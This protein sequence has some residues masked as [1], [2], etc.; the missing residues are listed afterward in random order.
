MVFKFPDGVFYLGRNGD[1]W[2]LTLV[3]LLQICHRYCN[4][5]FYVK[6]KEFL[7]FDF[8]LLSCV[9]QDGLWA[10]IFSCTS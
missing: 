6:K 8:A 3:E 9:H 1:P 7:L 2:G 5:I 10:L 4:S